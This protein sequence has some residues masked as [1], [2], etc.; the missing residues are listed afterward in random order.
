MRDGGGRVARGW[1]TRG[2]GERAVGPLLGPRCGWSGECGRRG[3]FPEGFC[4][5]TSLLCLSL[6]FTSC[7]LLAKSQHRTRRSGVSET[8]KKLACGAYV[9]RSSSCF[10]VSRGPAET[11]NLCMPLYVVHPPAWRSGDLFRS[12][13]CCQTG[14]VAAM[15][16]HNVATSTLVTRA[17]SSRRAGGRVVVNEFCPLLNG[18]ESATELVLRNDASERCLNICS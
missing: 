1:R 10:S 12:P 2:R 17:R 8:H 16:W 14:V 13:L 4:W 15:Y 3:L 18:V 11:D 6:F 9:R 7:C 5:E